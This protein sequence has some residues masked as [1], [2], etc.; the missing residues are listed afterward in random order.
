MRYDFFLIWGH[1]IK[2]IDDIIK[3]ISSNDD[4]K[5]KMILK[6]KVKNIK[7]FVKE[8]YKYDYVPYFHLRSKTKYLLDTQKEVMFIFIIN[9]NPQEIW[10]LGHGTGHIES[11]NIVRYKNIIRDKFNE[12]KDDR[13]TENHV[14][15]A[16]DNEI[17]VHQMLKYLNYKDG[18]NTFKRHLNKPF[19]IPYFIEEFSESVI[20]EVNISLLK[21]NII[22]DFKIKTVSI[23]KSPQYKFLDGKENIYKEYIQKYQ[24]TLLKSYYALNK[25]KS[26]YENFNYL[27]N[28]NFNS[29]IIVKKVDDHYLILDG[30]HRASILRKKGIEKVKVLEIIK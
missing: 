11:E 29:F 26:L 16:S 3:I 24:G 5:I 8:V 1:G 22:D 21:C 12:R 20:Q 27:K 6:H 19:D 4:F 14:V 28:Q 13:R 25:Y 30:L 15:H 7:K 2:Y 17:Q 10:K 18:I 9:K 23:E